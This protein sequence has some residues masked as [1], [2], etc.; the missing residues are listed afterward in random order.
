MPFHPAV[1]VSYRG[2][3]PGGLPPIYFS[4]A[5]IEGADPQ[6]SEAP[7]VRVIDEREPGGLSIGPRP[8]RVTASLS[9]GNLAVVGLGLVAVA[10]LVFSLRK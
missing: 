4:G 8:R 2:G 6:S 9:S 10:A 7:P 5:P 1:G 3:L